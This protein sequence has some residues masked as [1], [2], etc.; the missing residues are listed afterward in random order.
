MP[1]LDL[2]SALNSELNHLPSLEFVAGS[3]STGT[4]VVVLS[5]ADRFVHVFEDDGFYLLSFHRNGRQQARGRAPD[6]SSAADSARRWVE[7]SGLESLAAAHPFVKF[8]GLQLAYERGTAIEF[9]WAALLKAVEEEENA[10]RDLVIMA[11]RDH[12]LKQFFP[13]LG[14]RFAL[15]ADEYSDGILVAVFFYRPGW[16]VIFGKGEDGGFEFEGNATQMVDYLVNR[17]CDQISR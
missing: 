11:S 9:Q 15:S 8:S 7:G 1:E 13:H 4:A 5:R 16:F 14:H 10:Y 17:L 6:V 12:C 3:G 2:V